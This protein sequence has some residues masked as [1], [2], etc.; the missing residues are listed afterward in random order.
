MRGI[1]KIWGLVLLGL[2][3]IVLREH[4]G[5]ARIIGTN[6]TGVSSDLWCNGGRIRGNT[7]ILATE[8]CQ[9][10]SGNWI[11]TNNATQNLGTSA[12]NWGTIFTQTQT[13]SGLS[14]SGT[15]A[16]SGALGVGSLTAPT[17]SQLLLNV[18]TAS[19]T[20]EFIQTQ[21]SATAD[22][23]QTTAG[24]TVVFQIGPNGHVLLRKYAKTAIDT[25]VPDHGVG[26]LIIDTNGTLANQVCIAT[27][28][29]VAQWRALQGP[30]ALGCGSNN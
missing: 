7:T 8:I 26:D 15:E 24:N 17:T 9:D 21:P 4:V 18:L 11:P 23:F 29:A 3:A 6:P 14:T 13:N 20:G 30:A 10:S 1:L 5:E 28:T 25:L 22:A 12:L 16:I 19:T 2:I 27:G